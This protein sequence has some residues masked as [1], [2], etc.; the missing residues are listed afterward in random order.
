MAEAIDPCAALVRDF[1]RDRY[2]ATLF[3]PADRR[4]H[5]FALYAFNVEISRI[6]DVIREALTGEIRMQWWRETV[7]GKRDGEAAAHPVAS[8]LLA[9]IE[10]NALPRQ[11]FLDLMESRIFDLYNDP[12][13]TTHDLEGYCGETASALIRLAMIILMNG[14]DAGAADAAGHAG[15]AQGVTGIL[16]SLPLHRRRGQCYI[17]RDFLVRHDAAPEDLVAGRE[18]E[19]LAATLGDLRGVARS[20][21][22]KARAFA[23]SIPSEARPAFLPVSLVEGDLDRMDRTTTESL[24]EV[25]ETP[26]WRRQIRLWHAARR[27]RF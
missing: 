18:P 16:R 12:M 15:V 1:D 25:I 24:N 6:R 10:A 20:H 13:P 9:T 14:R 22:E 8:R 17:P 26:L 7:E 21:L 3:A 4:P 27:G 5:L 2:L 23:D 11:A 19:R